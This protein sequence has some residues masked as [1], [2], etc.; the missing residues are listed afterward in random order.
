MSEAGSNPTP[1]PSPT[2]GSGEQDAGR[3]PLSAPEG[4]PGGEV[5]PEPW[6]VL[7]SEYLLRS[8]WRDFRKDRVRLHTGDEIVYSY[9]E[10]PDAAFVV[11]LTADG[12]IATVRQYRH[13]VRAWVWEVVGGGVGP[14]GPL[15]TARKELKEEIGIPLSPVRLK[16]ALLGLGVLKLA[17]HKGRGT[18]LPEE[19]AGL[20]EL[21]LS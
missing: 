5:K 6:E 19:W 15:G 17:L 8:P 14:E 13:P 9:M 20:D 1:N 18:P 16:C 21:E 4:G 2:H 7:D 3:L 12:R 11:P 10:A